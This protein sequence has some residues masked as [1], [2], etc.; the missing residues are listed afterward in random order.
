[1]AFC[2]PTKLFSRAFSQDTKLGWSFRS[3]MDCSSRDLISMKFL[4]ENPLTQIWQTGKDQPI[5]LKWVIFKCIPPLAAPPFPRKYELLGLGAGFKAPTSAQGARPGK[6]GR[7]KHMGPRW[8]P[9]DCT[10]GGYRERAPKLSAS[11][12]VL[13]AALGEP[14]PGEGSCKT[15][16]SPLGTQLHKGDAQTAGRE[17]SQ[18]LNFPPSCTSL[19]VACR[20]LVVFIRGAACCLHLTRC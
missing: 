1:M 9:D 12:A 2:I 8:L 20:V 13:L 18:K 7:F 19:A 6:H 5:P 16:A 4:H 14:G 3:W 10:W 11:P 15:L 17:R